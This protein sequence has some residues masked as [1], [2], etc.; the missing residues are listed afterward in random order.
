M[1]YLGRSVLYLGATSILQ[2][3]II[4]RV[5]TLRSEPHRSMLIYYDDPDGYWAEGA[6]APGQL[7]PARGLLK[8][9][10]RCCDK[11]V[12]ASTPSFSVPAKSSSLEILPTRPRAVERCFYTWGW[13]LNVAR[14]LSPVVSIQCLA[15]RTSSCH[16]ISPVLVSQLIA[17][18]FILWIK[19]S[20]LVR[21]YAQIFIS[22]LVILLCVKTALEVDHQTVPRHLKGPYS[23]NPVNRTF[24]S[25][26]YDL[27]DLL[28][29]EREAI[30]CST[31]SVHSDITRHTHAPAQL[32]ALH[33]FLEGQQDHSVA[34][35]HSGQRASRWKCWAN[36]QEATHLRLSD[37]F[38]SRC[39]HVPR[40]QDTLKKTHGLT[41]PKASGPQKYSSLTRVQY[42]RCVAKN[43][44]PVFVK[45]VMWYFRLDFRTET[46]RPKGGGV[47]LLATHA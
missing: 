12:S 6:Y 33:F 28:G 19:S 27:S 2:W 3:D 9:K 31:F 39:Q 37:V 18:R 38:A 22:A 35:Y 13:V 24:A 17:M 45:A 32:Q 11:S 1:T 47:A 46:F 4:Q 42:S 34:G 15:S 14:L 26:S 44:H 21:T 20:T 5:G 40:N 25:S 30:L 7:Y 23:M 36:S 43:A 16:H 10:Q 41:N 29:F 8:Y